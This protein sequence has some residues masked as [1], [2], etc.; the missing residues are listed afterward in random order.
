MSWLAVLPIALSMQP[1][2]QFKSLGVW[3]LADGPDTCGIVASFKGKPTKTLLFMVKGDRPDVLLMSISSSTWGV[4]NHSEYDIEITFDE[5]R[6]DSTAV[7]FRRKDS[8]SL[9]TS[10]DL[11]ALDLIATARTIDV[12]AQGMR[13]GLLSLDG[14]ASAVR[15][16]RQCLARMPATVAA[17]AKEKEAADRLATDPF[18]VISPNAPAK[19]SGPADWITQDD[20]PA[21]ALNSGVSGTV[22]YRFTVNEQGRIE[23]CTITASSGDAA[24]DRATC[25]TLTRRGRYTPSGRRI[26]EGEHR[27][28]LPER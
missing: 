7:G 15:H 19:I 9:M 26:V 16:M 21:S 18:T 20:Y 6:L 1:A 23:G 4:Q 24:L 28:E 14:S 17:K 2:T 3:T 12:A 8:G 22:G 27:W 13:L 5:R 10:F 25:M 11:S